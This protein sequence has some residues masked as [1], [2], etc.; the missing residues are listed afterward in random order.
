MAD[1]LQTTFKM[2]VIESKLF[3]FDSNI[4]ELCS[5]GPIGDKSALVQ[6]MVKRRTGDKP[7]AKPIITQFN[8]TQLTAQ[9]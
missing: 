8:D 2:H 4:P 5:W 1:I 6:V 3:H 7:L 9:C